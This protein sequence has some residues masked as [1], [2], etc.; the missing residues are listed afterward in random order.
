MRPKLSEE[1][2]QRA[3]KKIAH[4]INTEEVP[5]TPTGRKRAAAMALSMARAHRL[6]PTGNYRRK[7]K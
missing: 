3:S 6:S 2:Q 4:L 1:E 5:N 7:K